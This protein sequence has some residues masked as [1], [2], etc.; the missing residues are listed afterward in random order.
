MGK[1]KPNKIDTRRFIDKV[2]KMA[3][4]RMSEGKVVSLDSFRSVDMDFPRK[5][6]IIE[7]DETMRKAM[8]RIFEADGYEVVTVSDGTHLSQVLDDKPMDLIILDIGLPWINGFELAQLMKED[9]DLKSIPL[10]FVSGR[11]GDGD[12]RKGFEIGAVDFVKK[13]FDVEKI[14]KTVRTLLYLN[15]N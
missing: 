13:P 9:P 12:I 7:D 15:E 11:T 8:K 5:I 4:D 3:K 1:K 10:I 2:K 14:R 6:L